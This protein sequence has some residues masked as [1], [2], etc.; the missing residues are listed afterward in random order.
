MSETEQVADAMAE[1]GAVPALLP[2]DMLVE[3]FRSLPPP[4]DVIRCAAAG[5]GSSSAVRM[6]RACPRRR[7]TS[8]SS[9]TTACPRCPIRRPPRRLP[10]VDAAA[11][12]RTVGSCRC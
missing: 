12:A 2:D 1:T 5:V 8:I 6:R 10:P 7:D 3:V 11:W 4:C 9:S